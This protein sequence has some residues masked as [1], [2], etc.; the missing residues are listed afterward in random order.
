M[1]QHK[2]DTIICIGSNIDDKMNIVVQALSALETMC[3]IDTHSSF[4]EC[5]DESGIGSPY[6]N[7]VVRCVP[8]LGFDRFQSELKKLE[9]KFGRTP[10]SK[11]S[12][13]MPLD[14]DIVVWHNKVVDPFEFSRSYFRKGLEQI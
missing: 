14:I 4:Y 3:R 5:P 11:S 2:A 8:T 12:G 10:E 13:I 6:V 9:Q 1:F 7:V